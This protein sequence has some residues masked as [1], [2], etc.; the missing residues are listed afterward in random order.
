LNAEQ[1]HRG[2]LQ[3]QTGE[4]MNPEHGDIFVRFR[5][6]HQPSSFVVDG[7]IVPG[8]LVD[9]V[10]YATLVQSLTREGVLDKEEILAYL[11]KL[12]NHHEA[13]LWRDWIAT[14]QAVMGLNTEHLAFKILIETFT[15]GFEIDEINHELCDFSKGTND[16]RYDYI[17]HFINKTTLPVSEQ[18]QLFDDMMSSPEYQDLDPSYQR[19]AIRTALQNITQY[20]VPD[21]NLMTMDQGFLKAYATLTSQQNNQRV[22]FV[23][24]G[25]MMVGIPASESPSLPQ[26]VLQRNRVLNAEKRQKLTHDKRMEALRHKSGAWTGHPFFA[27]DVAVPFQTVWATRRVFKA[28]VDQ[29]PEHRSIL[30]R[31]ILTQPHALPRFIQHTLTPECLGQIEKGV[32][33]KEIVAT[34]EASL[35]ELQSWRDELPTEE[36]YREA[37]RGLVDYQ[38]PSDA[39]SA[40]DLS[41]VPAELRTPARFTEA[42]LLKDIDVFLTYVTNWIMGEGCI[43]LNGNFEDKATAEAARSQLRQLLTFGT[44]F[45]LDNGDVIEFTPTVFSQMCGARKSHLLSLIK[46]D[47]FTNK[48]LKD[49]NYDRPLVAPHPAEIVNLSMRLLELMVLSDQPIGFIDD[50]ASRFMYE[51]VRQNRQLWDDAVKSL[52]VYDRPLD[53]SSLPDLVLKER[54]ALQLETLEKEPVKKK[55][56]QNSKITLSEEKAPL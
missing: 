24:E 32:S 53:R 25:G 7:D 48:P 38:G 20:E 16:G 28:L 51:P 15:S 26:E 4:R 37:L 45:T 33:S 30:E 12:Q 13:R 29:C 14:A 1:A 21:L 36:S 9:F 10:A 40:A 8:A 39:V 6:L 56:D 2:T 19:L 42:G 47:S 27:S 11:P 55:S 44:L 52:E 43:P 18:K 22:G 35:T 23:A 54:R 3:T 17:F 31:L 50:L 41:V 46:E 49:P 5:A 34:F